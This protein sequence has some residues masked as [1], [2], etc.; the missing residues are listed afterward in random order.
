MPADAADW[1]FHL[2]PTSTLIDA[3]SD[4]DPDGSPGDVGAF[5]GAGADGW[6]LDAD[7]APSWWQPGVYDTATYP[8]A[9]WDCDDE[10]AAVGPSS[11]C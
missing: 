7:G 1:D 5:G 8:A 4:L 6:D 10:D 9:G 3:G 11:G 2:D